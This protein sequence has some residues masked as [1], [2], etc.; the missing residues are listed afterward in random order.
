M[1][2]SKAVRTRRACARELFSENDA[3]IVRKPGAHALGTY[4]LAKVLHFVKAKLQLSPKGKLK[5]L[6]R[7]L[8]VQEILNE[9]HPRCYYFMLL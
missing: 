8:P 7:Q 6:G 1:F 2:S 3:N 4:I 9:R 5:F